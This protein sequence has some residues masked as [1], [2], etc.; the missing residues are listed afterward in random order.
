M[1]EKEYSFRGRHASMVR[2]MVP[3]D[4]SK[5]FPI[6]NRNFDVYLIAPIIGFM[7]GE[8]GLIDTST[9]IKTDIFP[10]I[11]IKNERDLK[12]NFQLIMLLDE[13]YE[14]DFNNRINKA[15]KH[16]SIPDTIEDEKRYNEYVLGGVE[17]LYNKIVSNSLTIDDCLD[18]FYDF[19]EEF[20]ERYNNTINQ[21]DFEELV[22]L[23]N[24]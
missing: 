10:E 22:R 1:F 14:K 16:S 24:V 15:F 12:Y 20:E 19:I 2:A 3:N 21:V 18:N 13:K 11:L 8:H 6:F 23:A 5:Y 7:Y 17:I 9:Q 4:V